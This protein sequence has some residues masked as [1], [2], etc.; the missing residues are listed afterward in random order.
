DDSS[1]QPSLLQNVQESLRDTASSAAETVKNLIWNA[2]PESESTGEQPEQQQTSTKD[3]QAK[4]VD[5]N[6]ADQNVLSNVS[7]ADSASETRISFSGEKIWEDQPNT[8]RKDEPIV[9]ESVSSMTEQEPAGAV[10]KRKKKKKVKEVK[11]DRPY[12][13]EGTQDVLAVPLKA[14]NE[15]VS[16]IVSTVESSS[17]GKT[18]E[19]FSSKPEKSVNDTTAV[20][21]TSEENSHE[22]PAGENNADGDSNKQQ[23]VLE[24]RQQTIITPFI[25][26][27]EKIQNVI[28]NFTDTPQS[29]APQQLNDSQNTENVI[30]DVMNSQ[31]Q[32]QEIV[33]HDLTNIM[34]EILKSLPDSRAE[35]KSEPVSVLNIDELIQIVQHINESVIEKNVIDPQRL[36]NTTNDAIKALN[37]LPENTQSVSELANIVQQIE[38]RLLESKNKDN[39]TELSSESSKGA[40]AEQRPSA[41]P[42]LEEIMNNIILSKSSSSDENKLLGQTTTTTIFSPFSSSNI[43][44]SY[45]LPKSNTQEKPNT[46][47]ADTFDDIKSTKQP[48]RTEQMLESTLHPKEELEENKSSISATPSSSI[49]EQ[50]TLLI[51]PVTLVADVFRQHFKSNQKDNQIGTTAPNIDQHSKIIKEVDENTLKQE[52]KMNESRIPQNDTLSSSKPIPSE[53]HDDDK[54]NVENTNKNLSLIISFPTEPQVTELIQKISNQKEKLKTQREGTTISSA[55]QQPSETLATSTVTSKSTEKV[56]L[57]EYTPISDDTAVKS[58]EYAHMPQ[59]PLQS[60]ATNNISKTSDD[61]MTDFHSLKSTE[62]FESDTTIEEKVIHPIISINDDKAVENT[63]TTF[64]VP[65]TSQTS[66]DGQIK[67]LWEN[68]HYAL[69]QSLSSPIASPMFSSIQQSPELPLSN[70]KLEASFEQQKIHDV[71]SPTYSEKRPIL[72]GDKSGETDLNA[73]IPYYEIKD[74]MIY[75]EEKPDEIVNNESQNNIVAWTQQPSTHYISPDLD[76]TETSAISSTTVQ[77]KQTDQKPCTTDNYMDYYLAR[78]YDPETKMLEET[79]VLDSSTKQPMAI[80]KDDVAKNFETSNLPITEYTQ[81]F[82]TMSNYGERQDDISTQPSLLDDSKLE[83]NVTGLSQIVN[84]IHNAKEQ[85][86]NKTPPTFSEKAKLSPDSSHIIDKEEKPQK[87]TSDL[88][89]HEQSKDESVHIQS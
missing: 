21:L 87:A 7:S 82:G 42:F 60:Q 44:S 14:T 83:M 71:K 49:I 18:T 68:R 15:L 63:S 62:T 26:S 36:T 55:V 1:K 29:D 89:Q 66:I 35:I 79:T 48:R 27:D 19:I 86:E 32:Q 33:V 80:S 56:P 74:K 39:I 72:D 25:N 57:F 59:Q 43:D 70:S 47:L 3:K 24:T 28:S 84:S 30:S 73:A 50:S 20:A 78:R 76:T 58:E 16:K 53:K 23:A 46:A 61:I 11:D 38:L 65:D 34:S 22:K 81:V 31:N 64:F 4:H 2:T 40:A 51:N 41:H 69:E 45:I 13:M 10:T 88:I 85:I 54:Q 6:R 77:E 52:V 75:A 5:T 9:V 37:E 67:D 8:G 12:V 17:D